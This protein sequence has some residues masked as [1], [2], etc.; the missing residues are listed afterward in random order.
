M[1]IFKVVAQNFDIVE[2]AQTGKIT[3]NHLFQANASGILIG[4]PETDDD[5]Q[6]INKKIKEIITLQKNH[7]EALPFNVIMIG[8]TF[9]EFS[10][11]SLHEIA[12]LLKDCCA[13][14][15]KDI[16]DEF[17]KQALLI[18][19]P[20][21]V[22]TSNEIEK[23]L[24]PSPKLITRV[25]NKMRDFLTERLHSEGFKVSLMYGEVSSPERAVEILANE[26]LQG[27]M[28][29]SA[30]KT[31]SQVLEFVKAIQFAYNKRKIILVCNFK[32]YMLSESY[33]EYL[34]ALAIVPDNFTVYFVP[35]ATGIS[36]LVQLIK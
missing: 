18:Y 15:F 31:S 4:H 22:T 19:E 2:E 33:Q 1:A 14:M 5:L 27:L 12:Q 36:H 32:S 16:P 9:K 29:G 3:C 23:Q 11:Y 35:P 28:L 26:N 34:S 30:C 24:P 10:K 25:T 20:K 6:T 21:W 13:E 17:I 8:E 7:P